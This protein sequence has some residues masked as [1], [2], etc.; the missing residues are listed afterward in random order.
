[1]IC[2]D[3]L[4]AIARARNPQ[5][6]LGQFP[7]SAVTDAAE[8]FAIAQ[9]LH[10][11]G[12]PA[13]AL[14]YLQK[15]AAVSENATALSRIAGLLR[16]GFTPEQGASAPA[17]R[18]LRLALLGDMNT[19]LFAPLVRATGF[20]MGFALEVHETGFGA[21]GSQILD[22][23]SE[24]Y[25]FRPDA[26]FVLPAAEALRC[27]IW[28]DDPDRFV[29]QECERWRSLWEKFQS[30]SAAPIVQLSYDTHG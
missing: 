14:P 30:H 20:G 15:A 11:T 9:A 3:M 22:G 10:K 17:A 27:T 5:E 18:S 23:S 1:M 6:I 21:M 26:V 12:C 8:L 29:Q 4:D 7:C 19:Q 28:I 24:L 16:R 2:G 25:Q 13:E